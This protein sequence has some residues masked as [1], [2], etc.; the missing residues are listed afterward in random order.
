M[1]K[2]VKLLVR[3]IQYININI[4]ICTTKTIK[5]K[6]TDKNNNSKIRTTRSN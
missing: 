5:N 3:Y 1:L 4:Y 2:N 6:N